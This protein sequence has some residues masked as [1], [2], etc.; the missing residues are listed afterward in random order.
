MKRFIVWY[1]I[2]LALLLYFL[3][4]DSNSISQSF[5]H[6]Q[7][8]TLLKMLS[9]WFEDRV[10][11]HY[12]VITPSY[13]ITIDRACNGVVTLLI[14][15]ASILAYQA[16]LLHKVLWIMVGYV[17][18]SLANFLRIVFVIYMVLQDPTHFS[19][20]HDYIGNGFLIALGFGL[21]FLFLQSSSSKSNLSPT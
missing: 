4:F 12:V 16:K 3:F 7:R 5:N 18:L 8:D 21:F 9:L 13:F 20:A 14:F 11:H 6:F 2:Y 19:W 17:V 15:I 1:P 10:V